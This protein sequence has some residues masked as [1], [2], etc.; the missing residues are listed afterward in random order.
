[1][2]RFKRFNVGRVLVLNNPRASS[3]RV[4][5]SMSPS[6]TAYA[7]PVSE[8]LVVAR[9]ARSASNRRYVTTADNDAVHA[10]VRQ[11]RAS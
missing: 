2:R 7:L 6:S 10:A 9:S 5:S 4:T 8:I 1:M 11:G 3:E